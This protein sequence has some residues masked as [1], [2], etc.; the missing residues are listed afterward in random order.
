MNTANPYKTKNK[1]LVTTNLNRLQN[2]NSLKN[3]INNCF[4]QGRRDINIVKMRKIKP[5]FELQKTF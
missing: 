2:L 4:I 3:K 5:P 1:K